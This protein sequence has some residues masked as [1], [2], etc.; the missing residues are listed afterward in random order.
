MRRKFGAFVLR[1]DLQEPS[2]ESSSGFCIRVSELPGSSGPSPGPSGS[3]KGQDPSSPRML[4][5]AEMADQEAAIPCLIL[6][7]LDLGSV[8]DKISEPGSTMRL[9]C[10]RELSDFPFPE[11]GGPWFICLMLGHRAGV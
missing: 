9:H 11:D 4:E 8:W 2:P 7:V 1:S 10:S 6:D 5:F 3:A